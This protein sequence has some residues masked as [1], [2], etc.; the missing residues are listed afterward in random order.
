MCMFENILKVILFQY[1][2]W[3]FFSIIGTCVLSGAG[4]MGQRLRALAVLLVH[5]SSVPSTH[6]KWLKVPCDL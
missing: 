5:L 4:E 6:I 1:Q 2:R 3:I